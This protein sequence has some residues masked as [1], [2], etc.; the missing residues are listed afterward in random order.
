MQLVVFS[1]TDRSITEIDDLVQLFEEGLQ[2]FHVRKPR[3]GKQELEDYLN[4]I[5]KKFHNRIVLHTFH[6]LRSDFRLKGLHLS[7]HHRTTKYTTRFRFR[8]LKLL[9]PRLIFTRSCHSVE[10]LNEEKKNYDYVFLSPIYSSISKSNYDSNLNHSEI[11]EA[12]PSSQ[13]NVFALGGI[14]I[15][16]L[17]DC[18]SMGFSGVALLGAIWNSEKKP[19]EAYR[20]ALLELEGI[21]A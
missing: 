18:R 19:I 4:A 20:Q 3:L 15:D 13:Q 17:S 10:E 7:R 16:K 9:N 12:L 8:R 5:P 2:T 14:D 1:S 11:M 21:P 6:R